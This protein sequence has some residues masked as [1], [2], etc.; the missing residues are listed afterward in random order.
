MEIQVGTPAT[1]CIGSDKYATFVKEV[2]LDKSGK[3]NYIRLARHSEIKFKLGSKGSWLEV[4]GYARALVG[5]ATDYLD[6]SF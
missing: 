2:N 5:V 3:I 1:F 6:P 4:G